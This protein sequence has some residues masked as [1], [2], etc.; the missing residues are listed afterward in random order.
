MICVPF[1]PH[2]LNVIVWVEQLCNW[3]QSVNWPQNRSKCEHLLQQPQSPFQS[4]A[5]PQN[6][7]YICMYTFIK[8]R[9]QLNIC[10][11][12]LWVSCVC[13]KCGASM[14]QVLI[15]IWLTFHLITL[16]S[17]CVCAAV[18]VQ[19]NDQSFAESFHSTRIKPL[20]RKTSMRTFYPLFSR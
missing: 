8:A 13:G 12:K 5:L 1:Q 3:N 11:W 19:V 16:L 10:N 2:Q 18:S 20:L 17:V 4:P 9:A 15:L 7:I 14:G 6:T